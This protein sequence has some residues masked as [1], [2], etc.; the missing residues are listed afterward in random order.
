MT[1]TA[2]RTRAGAPR[3]PSPQPTTASALITVR[4]DLLGAV[5]RWAGHEADRPIGG[6]AF[7][8]GTITATDGHRLVVVPHETHG[9][10]FC[11]TR[12]HLLAAIAAQDLLA[13]ESIDPKVG[14]DVVDTGTGDIALADGPYGDREIRLA[15]V[16]ATVLIGIGALEIQAPLLDEARYP[17]ADQVAKIIDSGDDSPSPDGYLLDARYLAAI[18]E[19]NTA[20]TNYQS[21]IRVVRW[22]RLD[23]A[24][25]GP[26]VLENRVGV[27]F[28]IMPQRDFGEHTS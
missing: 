19:V 17:A 6:V 14:Y 1:K 15:V 28:V 13:R 16:G 7:R 10:R 26:L 25:R 22:S 24:V 2:Q 21:G 27:K 4:T 18:E 12:N 23:G 11:V 9:M 3:V 20:T 5:A 8:D